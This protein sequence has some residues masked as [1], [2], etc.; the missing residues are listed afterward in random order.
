[1]PLIE[2]TDDEL[3]ALL[4]AHTSAARV[5]WS[6]YDCARQRIIGAGQKHME[7]KDPDGVSDFIAFARG[8]GTG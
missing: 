7:L 4:A 1:M 2:F 8:P 5:N 6:A 3:E